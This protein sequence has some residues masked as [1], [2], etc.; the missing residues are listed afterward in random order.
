[1]Q[2]WLFKTEPTTYSIEDLARC[3]NRTDSWEGV[4]NY[5]ARNF[6]K[7]METGDFGFFYHS[8]TKVPAIVGI[9]EVVKES[10]PDH[11]ALDKDSKYFD[12]RSTKENPIWE[13]VSVQLVGVFENPISLETLKAHAAA[14][15]G[16]EVIKKGSRL[17]VLPVS[18]EHFE[19]ILSLR[20]K[21]E[22]IG[23]ST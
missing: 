19:Y 3:E 4:R 15:E 8:N 5:Q 13:M 23:E 16:L 14:L 22:S 6:M 10:Y 7:E 12:K 1:M 17:S 2:F 21:D 18:P 9:V 11:T 20:K